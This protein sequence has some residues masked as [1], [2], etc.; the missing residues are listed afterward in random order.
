L[1]FIVRINDSILRQTQVQFKKTPQHHRRA[2]VTP[3]LDVHCG[4]PLERRNYADSVK[5]QSSKA[6][7]TPAVRFVCGF[8]TKRALLPY[9][10][11]T[12]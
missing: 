8:S 9:D 11:P 7:A 4:W 3:A 2:G 12:P 6:G 1:L 5:T 10:L